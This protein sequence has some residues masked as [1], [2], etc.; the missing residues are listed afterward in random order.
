MSRFVRRPDLKKLVLK[1]EKEP[2]AFVWFTGNPTDTA[3]LV[4][5]E[6]PITLFVLDA[7][8]VI[9]PRS[10]YRHVTIEQMQMA[11]KQFLGLKPE[12][13]NKALPPVRNIVRVAESEMI[14]SGYFGFQGPIYDVEFI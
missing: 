4:R 2:P 14:D 13:R 6:G 1:A 12:F 10:P 11:I 5:T 7:F 3:S 8:K 9:Q